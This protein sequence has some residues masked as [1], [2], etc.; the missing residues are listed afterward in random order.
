VRRKVVIRD[1][2]LE[3][4]VYIPSGALSKEDRE[5]ADRLDE[6]L[7]KRIPELAEGLDTITPLVRRWHEFGRRVRC[8][9][10]GS[11]LVLDADVAS[12]AFW[13]AVWQYLP[14]RARPRRAAHVE[15]YGRVLHKHMDHLSLCYEIAQLEWW[16]V[17]WLRRW[18]DWHQLAA[19][20]ALI[21]D[22]RIVEALGTAI[23]LMPHYP[24]G[25]QFREI[26]KQLGER[27]PTK[28]PRESRFLNDDEIVRI[29]GEA[30]S[31]VVAQPTH[32]PTG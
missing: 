2:L 5:R 20:P 11:S 16:Q 1:E 3:M 29:V 21:R 25:K 32:P 13:E 15:D 18:D 4:K 6:V 17:C 30:V 19:R 12:G 23:G 7:A 27:F 31:K 26:A 24:T 9:L 8:L 14:A 22:E 10:E 28:R